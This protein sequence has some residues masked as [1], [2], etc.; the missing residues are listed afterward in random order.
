MMILWA[1]KCDKL[2]WLLMR[3]SFSVK[4]IKGAVNISYFG[5][6]RV[7]SSHIDT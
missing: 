1:Y 4:I 2:E 3:G 5:F 7:L 6:F